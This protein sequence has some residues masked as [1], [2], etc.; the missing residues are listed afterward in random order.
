[1]IKL[2]SLEE[3]GVEIVDGDRGKNYPSKED[4]S[5]NGYCPFLNNKDIYN[6]F[7]F[8]DNPDCISE[9]RHKLL[10]KGTINDGDIIITT[11]GSV[12]NIGFF[13]ST[14]KYNFARIN[15]GMLI[16]KNKP[17]IINNHYLFFALNS[18][19]V[20]KQLD[21]Y[22]SG[23]TQK[24]LTLDDI[25]RL[26]IYFPDKNE[27]DYIVSI[28]SCLDEKILTNNQINKNLQELSQTLYKQWFLDFNFIDKAGKPYKSNKGKMVDSKLGEIPDKWI[29]GKF[30]DLVKKE[31]NKLSDKKDWNNKTLVDLANM[32]SN[33]ISLDSFD[34]G[35]KLNSNIYELKKYSFL[36]GSI[37]PY[38]RK[39]GFSPINGVTTGTIH[40]FTPINDEN[41]SFILSIFSSEEFFNHAI[42][43]SKGTKM[44]VIDWDD[45]IDYEIVI[46]PSEITSSFNSIIFPMV[47]MIKNNIL[48]NIKLKEIRDT[49]INYFTNK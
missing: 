15:S 26:K 48:E 32:P 22:K 5:K 12:G 46:P 38:Q 1:M 37:R 17:S 49:L 39:A 23:T 19:T 33:S 28:L 45:F 36:F 24:Q 27:Q 14:K 25:K 10:K 3:I 21:K 8:L 42:I 2:Y 4:F 40:N 30:G 41:Y 11:R 34:K 44:P 6:G 9:E 18:P 31:S 7:V 29:I 35:E 16:I 43:R 13:R 47:K 20:K